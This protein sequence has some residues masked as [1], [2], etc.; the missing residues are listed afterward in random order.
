M[1]FWSGGE[2]IDPAYTVPFCTAPCTGVL[3]Y[4]KCLSS[5]R[6]CG[7]VEFCDVTFRAGPPDTGTTY[8]PS[9]RLW[10]TRPARLQAVKGGPLPGGKSLILIDAPPATSIRF[11]SS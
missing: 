2:S 9:A 8:R 1:L 7:P 10:K 5:G 4:K 6:T 11:S 3:Q